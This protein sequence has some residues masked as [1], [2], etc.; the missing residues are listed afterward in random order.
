MGVYPG[1]TVL[2]VGKGRDTLIA[3]GDVG[4]GAVGWG[5][6]SSGEGVV[7]HEEAHVLE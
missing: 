1:L 7:T 4:A 3:V 2:R 6:V 5:T